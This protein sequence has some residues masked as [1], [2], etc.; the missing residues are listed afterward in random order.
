MNA[1]QIPEPAPRR[2]ARLAGL[3]Y[4][5]IIVCGLFAELAVRSRLIDFGDA[6]LTAANIEASI[7]LFR[8][9]LVAD[10]VMIVADVALAIVLY[11]LFLPVSPLLSAFA[12]AFRLIQAAVLGA[13]LLNL[14]LVD[15]GREHLANPGERAELGLLFLDA[16]RYGYDL[17]LVFFGISCVFLGALFLRSGFLP[18]PFGPLM[19]VAGVVY[20]CGSSVRFLAPDLAPTFAPVYGVAALAEI[21]TCLWLLVR[22]VRIVPRIAADRS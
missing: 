16:H 19:I 6:A 4:L 22:G 11:R 12:M 17:G 7:G 18:R 9:G 20:L 3:F 2:L 1:S 14:V 21:A 13:N 5:I 15:L 10:V 8:A